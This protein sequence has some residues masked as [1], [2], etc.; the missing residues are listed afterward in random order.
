MAESNYTAT[1]KKCTKCSTEKSLDEFHGAARGMYGRTSVCKICQSEYAKRRYRNNRETLKGLSNEKY[2]ER[3]EPVRKAKREALQL[4]LSDPEKTCAKCGE[5]KPKSGFGRDKKRPDGHRPYCKLCHAMGNKLWRERNPEASAAASSNWKT[6]NKARVAEKVREYYSANPETYRDRA[7]RWRLENP[8]KQKEVNVRASRKRRI[9]IDVK[10]HDSVG[11]RLRGS[12]R[13]GKDWVSTFAILGYSLKALMT[14]LERQ[15][16]KGMTWDNYG[17]WHI[18]HI[19]P[20]SSFEILHL[21][22]P[23]I[24]E[25][26]CLTN[27]RPLWAKDNLSKHA[28]ITHLI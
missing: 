28:K 25:A 6:N 24:R 23:T 4:R 9:R 27:L 19:T 16:L 5:I 14:H 11:N 26:W 3:M 18:D 12:I 10:I 1:S 22:D 13:E 17:E 8:E 2:H 7:R 21:D 15:F 20:L